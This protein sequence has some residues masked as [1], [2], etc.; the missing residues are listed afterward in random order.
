MIVSMS[1]H[2]I[3]ARE[4]RGA[5]SVVEIVRDPA[6][7]SSHLEDAAHYAGGYAAGV[8]SPR[9]EAEVAWLVRSAIRVLPVGAQ[10][11]LTGGATP[12][13]DVVL[14]TARMSAIVGVEPD[15]VR[16]QAGVP[17]AALQEALDGHSLFYPPVPTFTGAFVG[18]V[19]ATNAAGATTFK[20]GTTRDWVR[21][22][23][24]VLA[25]GEVLDLERGAVTAHPDGF[26]EIETAAGSI[27][28]PVPTLRMPDVPK[29]SAGYYAAPGMDLVDLF[30]GSEGTLGVITEVTLR[31]IPRPAGVC[32]ALV[33]LN[34]QTKAI[35]LAAQLRRASQDTRRARDIRGVDVVA[36]E[37]MDR[38]SLDLIRAD[39]TDRRLDVSLPYD[40]DVL[41]LVQLEL[42]E[43][44]ARERAWQQLA[45][46]LSGAAPDTPLVRFC[47]LLS[48]A[49]ALDRSEVTL[50]G[51]SHR[52][53]QLM[54]LRE[55]VPVAVNQRIA[56]AKQNV[57]QS[58]QKTAADIVVPFDR[59]AEMMT[60]C[61]HAFED[62]HLD[63]AVWG[64]IS[65]G[66]V[67][68]NLIP[69]TKT[70]VEAGCAAVRE[71]GR[72]VIRLGGC[73]LAEHGVGR[74]PVKQALLADLYGA[75]GV[76]EM[77]RVKRALD[78]EGK[79]APGV[80]FPP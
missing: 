58:I 39:E 31:V 4:P 6:V 12:M 76:Q 69:R 60:A 51:D 9:T 8:A 30:V 33:P 19:V 36:I 64:H 7:L 43:P 5:A 14:T 42:Q 61:R 23:T 55:A 71:L 1:A 73:P 21:G 32:T 47:R 17:L 57:D 48:E 3:R 56:L 63:Y 24:V 66:N 40:T 35:E 77:R 34:S 18:G 80:L 54:E 38:R 37:H 44:I 68:P 11:S 13:G 28:V 53:Q 70:D 10:S 72:E 45:D 16:V 59:F 29:R 26:F 50:P 74:H 27:R 52:T 79:L 22:V 67:H 75:G 20:Y 25:S 46:A 49:G 65:D 2:R 62:R 41:L 15:R 78:P